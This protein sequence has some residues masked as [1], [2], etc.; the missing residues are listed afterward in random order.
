MHDGVHVAPCA[1]VEVQS[2]R[3]PLATAPEASQELPL[4]TDVS[5]RV[6]ALQDLVPERVYPLLQIGVHDEPCA[7][8]EVQSDPAAAP[9]DIAPDASHGSGL[10]TMVSVSVP[11][12]HDLVPE[13]V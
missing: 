4:H 7:S 12:V 6:P 10:H 8:V 13:R 2:F 11:A 3:A 5:V 1:R 9:F